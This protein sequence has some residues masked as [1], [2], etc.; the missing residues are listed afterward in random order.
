MVGRAP[1]WMAERLDHWILFE[2]S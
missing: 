1:Q 2:K